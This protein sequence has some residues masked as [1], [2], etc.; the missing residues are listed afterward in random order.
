MARAKSGDGDRVPAHHPTISPELAVKRL[1]KLLEQIPEIRSQGHGSHA[2]STWSG[3]VKIVLG[4]FYG[5]HSLVFKEFDGIWFSP[6][7]YYDGQPDSEFVTAFNSGLN[8]ATGFLESRINDLRERLGHEGQLTVPLPF[9]SH[10]DSG[11]IFVVH[12]HDHGS[13]ETV[14]RFLGKLDLEPVILHEQADQGRTL[15]EKFE[16]HA[17]DVRAAVVI[18]TA[19]DTAA[20]NANPEK[21]ELRARQN[22]I[23]ELGFFV[24]RLGRQ[25]T[26][27]LVEKDVAL[28]SDL[29]GLIYIP[30]DREDWRLRLVKELKAAGLQV[31]ANRAL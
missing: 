2:I 6:G 16:D 4:E 19:D 1:Q 23:L 12:G 31:D 9:Q 7:G 18:L 10:P 21:K 22:V 3:N 5:E 17:A 27:A 15:I 20:S 26:F 24:G 29:H 8:Q 14:A 25:H 11:R 13:K 30:L 28:P